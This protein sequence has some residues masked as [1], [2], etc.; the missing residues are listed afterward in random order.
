[1]S[2]SEESSEV[3]HTVTVDVDGQQVAHV[4]LRDESKADAI[5]EQVLNAVEQRVPVRIALT[6]DAAAAQGHFTTVVLDPAGCTTVT[7]RRYPEQQVG[8]AA[9]FKR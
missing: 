4:S 5:A 9:N 2:G 6:D 3:L 8:G 1:V 7:V